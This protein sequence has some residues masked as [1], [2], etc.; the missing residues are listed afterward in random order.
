MNRQNREEK[1]VFRRWQRYRLNMP[2]RLIVSR[3]NSTR[4]TDGRANDISDGGLLI[5]AGF[6]LSLGDDVFVEFTPPFSGEAVRARGVIRHRRGYNYGVQFHSETSLEE[7]QIKKFRSLLSMAA[8][9]TS[10]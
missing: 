1:G 10:S 8:G 7:D 2:V 6:E 5:F 4:I 3:D 9:T